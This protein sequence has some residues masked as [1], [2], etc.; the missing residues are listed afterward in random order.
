L[1]IF[2]CTK[3]DA[4]LGPLCQ[5]QLRKVLE[6]KLNR[7]TKYKC[8]YFNTNTHLSQLL[9]SLAGISPTVCSNNKWSYTKWYI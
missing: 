1:S 3:H 7:R 5:Y 9:P 4:N 6:V 8:Q 2:K